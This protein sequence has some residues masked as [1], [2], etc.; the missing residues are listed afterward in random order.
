MQVL[1]GIAVSPGVAI[2]EAVII[3]QEGFRIPQRFVKRDAVDA[4]LDRLTSAIESVAAGISKNR[5]T[6]SNQLGEKYGAIFSAHLQMLRDER[7]NQEFE[8]LIRERHYTPEYAVSRTLRRYAKVFLDLDS[9]YHQERAHDIFDIEKSLLRD[10]LGR[11]REELSHI[12]SPVIVLAHNLTPSETANLNRQ[13]VLGFVTEIGGALGHTAIVAKGMEI[14]AVVGI[15]EFLTDVS[16]G[17]FVIVDGDHGRVIL[18]PDEETVARYRHE[19]EE[20]KTHIASLESLKDLP[21][22][23]L[24]GERIKITANIEFPQE[25]KQCNDRGGDGVGL[26]RTEFLYLGSEEE[27]TEEDHFQA[28]AEVVQAMDGR[29]TVIRTLDLGADKMGHATPSKEEHNPFLGLRSIRLSLK[30]V[31]LF[32]TQL[33]AV[34]RASALGTVRLM[35]PLISTL[36]EL[37]KAKMVL[38]DAMEDLDEQ[39]VAYDKNISVGMMV[40][41]PSAV[42]MIDQFVREVDF[43][44]IGTNDLAQY[45]LAVDRS[46]K[47]VSHLYQAVDPAVLRLIN[48]S[49]QAAKDAGIPA[50]VCGQM[51]STPAYAIVLLGLG[52]RHVSVTPSA[53]PEIK[54]LCRNVTIE[55]CEQVAQRA[56]TMDNALEIDTFLQEELRRA[57]PVIVPHLPRT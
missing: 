47:E 35:F 19:L 36:D 28:Y 23:T 12:C 50:S 1:Q 40:E 41:V 34:L 25:V 30:N 9:T 3:D 54:K 2:G 39:G 55:Q 31:T 56:L 14:P 49:I 7:L 53:L 17:E 16:G 5:D 51:S 42:V 45:A 10:L 44:S 38:K 37:R 43:I 13:F 57:I 32:R 6:V 21:A 29:S 27:P 15:G 26:Y 18:Q 24:D 48:T 20:H 4:E 46:N 8:R 33:R 11:R 22:E 52:I